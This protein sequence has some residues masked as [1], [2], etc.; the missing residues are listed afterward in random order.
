MPNREENRGTPSKKIPAL[1]EL[2]VYRNHELMHRKKFTEAKVLEFYI[3]WCLNSGEYNRA[4]LYDISRY[5][6]IC[7]LSGYH[8][9]RKGSWVRSL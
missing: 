2:E 8:R 9:N 1:F 5:P 3:K 6:N 4:I 7:P